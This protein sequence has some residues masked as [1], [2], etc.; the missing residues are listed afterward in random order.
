MEKY[1]SPISGKRKTNYLNLLEKKESKE[2][3]SFYFLQI[4]IVDEQEPSVHT[5]DIARELQ[6]RSGEN[7][8]TKTWKLTIYIWNTGAILEH[9]Y[10]SI[11]MK[12]LYFKVLKLTFSWRRS[13]SNETSS[14]IFRGNQCT[15]FYMILTSVMRELRSNMKK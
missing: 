4:T 6:F 11:L 13:V 10:V 9:N 12:K 7:V 14:L 15:G 2:L 3:R 1:L 8:F 5:T